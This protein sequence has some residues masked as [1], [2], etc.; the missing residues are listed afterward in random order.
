MFG[1]LPHP[2]RECTRWSEHS[3]RSRID[4]SHVLPRVSDPPWASLAG[5]R[6][7]VGLGVGRSEVDRTMSAIVGI[8]SYMHPTGSGAV[9]PA[10]YEPVGSG[11]LTPPYGV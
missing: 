5:P 4:F 6:T 11:S 9:W 7:G 8:V 2:Q 3:P 10:E 1:H